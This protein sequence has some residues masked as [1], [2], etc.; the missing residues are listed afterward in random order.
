MIKEDYVSFEVAKLLKEKGMAALN[1]CYYDKEGVI[2]DV[3]ELD[4]PEAVVAAHTHQMA[5]KWLRGIH[6]IN[7]GIVRGLKVITSL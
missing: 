4:A 1:H 6:N 7:I 2:H 3:M 5:L